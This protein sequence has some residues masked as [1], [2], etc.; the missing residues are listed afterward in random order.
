MGVFTHKGLLMKIEGTGSFPI[1]LAGVSNYQEELQR[2]KQEFVTV[3]LIE[4]NDNQY[5]KNAVKAEIE[6]LKVGYLSRDNAQRY[7]LLLQGFQRTGEIVKFNGK[8]IEWEEN[9]AVNYTV[10]IDIPQLL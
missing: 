4:E 2:V 1:R 5:D 3:N 6:G 10:R 8:I 7:R 9:G